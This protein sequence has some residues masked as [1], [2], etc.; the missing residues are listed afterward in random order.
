MPN[1]GKGKHSKVIPI[2]GVF[3]FSFKYLLFNSDN[4]FRWKWFISPFHSFRRIKSQDKLN[5]GR[6]FSKLMSKESMDIKGKERKG[7]SE[8]DNRYLRSEFPSVCTLMTSPNPCSFHNMGK[9]KEK[10]QREIYTNIFIQKHWQQTKPCATVL[11]E[12]KK[13]DTLALHCN[14]KLPAVKAKPTLRCPLQHL[15]AH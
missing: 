13:G 5:S 15:V 3:F 14:E 8:L 11:K 2:Q 7:N 4:K 1:L 6:N 9:N 10:H 12:K